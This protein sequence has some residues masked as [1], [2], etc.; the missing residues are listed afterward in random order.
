MEVAGV[1]KQ[2][3]AASSALDDVTFKIGGGEVV[4]FIGHNGAGKTTLFDAIGGF[5]P[6]DGGTACSSAPAPTA[7]RSPACRRT[8]EAWLGLGRSFQDGRLF[9]SMSVAETC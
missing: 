2:L 1:T 4:G 9:P 3:L 8:S 7:S 6:I 5:I